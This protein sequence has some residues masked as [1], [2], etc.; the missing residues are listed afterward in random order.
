[1]KEIQLEQGNLIKIGENAKEN[2]A[3]ID[4]SEPEWWWFHLKSFPSS[5]VILETSE[6]T[7]EDLIAAATWCKDTT[8]YRNLKNLKISYC[9]IKN[10]KKAEKVGSVTFVSNRKV[11]DIK[12]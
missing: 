2:W 11:K 10:I 5:H 6:P 7:N 1:M 8:K 12:L 4:A 3:L 9:Q